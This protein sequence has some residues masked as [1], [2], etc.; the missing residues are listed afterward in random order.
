MLPNIAWQVYHK[1]PVLTHMSELYR[2][3]L[4]HVSMIT[5]LL[6]QIM[7]NFSCLL[8]WMAGLVVLLSFRAEKRYRVFASIFL[9]VVLLFMLTKG[10]SYYPLGVYPVMMA[11]GGYYLEKYFPGRARLV[12]YFILAW[13]FMTFLL[14]VPLGLPLLPQKQMANYCKFLS[15]NITSAPMR[16]EQN[17]YYPL[18]QD[19]MDM[20]GWEELA[21]LA[22]VAYNRL[23][24]S[25]QK[26]C[27]VFANNYGQAGALDFYGKKYHLPTPVCL[28]DSYV[29]WAPDSLEARNYIITDHQPG[30]I[31]ELFERYIE[32]G[33]INNYY[34]RENGLKVYLCQDPKPGFYELVRK[35]IRM[36]KQVYE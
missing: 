6:E 24:S 31:P 10:K 27:I 4:V 18:P 36:R 23:D 2:T 22:A 11:F 1:F 21:G 32:I 19:Y 8:I 30:Q 17:G 3:Q 16:N 25:Q 28:N 26:D 7:M 15:E 20:T 29:F 5:F 33:A 13:S 12:S 9:L 35:E 34:F 14:L